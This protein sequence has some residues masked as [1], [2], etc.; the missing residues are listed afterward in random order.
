MHHSTLDKRNGIVNDAYRN[1]DIY[2]T[3]YAIWCVFTKSGTKEA[4]FFIYAK[5]DDAYYGTGSLNVDGITD[6]VN[7]NNLAPVA[8]YGIQKIT[9][10]ALTSFVAFSSNCLLV[11]NGGTF[12][13][14]D[15]L[16]SCSV[17]TYGSTVSINNVNYFAI[18]TNTLIEA[19]AT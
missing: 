17:V 19:P 7:F 12:S 2:V 15:S 11:A 4:A 6:M 18:G 14:L 9:Q 10:K 5:D 13:I 8:T 1:V 3:P 16:K